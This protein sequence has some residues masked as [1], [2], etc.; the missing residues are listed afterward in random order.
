MA[1]E[2]QQGGWL[3]PQYGQGPQ[4]YGQ[5]PQY[6]APPWAPGYFYSYRE[7]DN[8]TAMA[9][10]I[11]AAVSISVTVLFFGVL[12]PLTVFVS[13]AAVFVSRA[14]IKKVDRGETTKDRSLARWGF[15]LGIVGTLLALLAIAAWILVIV[16]NPDLFDEDPTPD[17]EPALAALPFR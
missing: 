11:M 7:P 2:Q 12:A 15:W 10:F 9:G 4:Q 14:G 5:P 6:G 3:P 17:G 16:N 1:D 13:I 8:H